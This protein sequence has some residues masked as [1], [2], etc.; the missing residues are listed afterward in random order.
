MRTTYD[1]RRFSKILRDNNYRL[2]RQSGR[3]KIYTNG[4]A[5]IAIPKK[6]NKIIA[7]RLIKENRLIVN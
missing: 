5:T 2:D 6:L 7:L 1:N 3:H 4:K